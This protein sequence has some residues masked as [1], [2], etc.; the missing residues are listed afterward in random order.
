MYCQTCG[1]EIQPGLNYCNRCGAQVNA[2]PRDLPAPVVV[3]LGSPMRWLA[4]TVCLTLLIGIT[5]LIFTLV[6]LSNMGV[7]GEPLVAITVFAFAAIFLTEFML[8]RLMSR[9]L[10]SAKDEGRLFSAKKKDKKEVAAPAPQQFI[11]PPPPYG[12][13]L[14]SVT[15]HTTRTFGPAYKEPRR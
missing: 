5:M 8:I 14:S 15:D 11:Q 10:M 3:D 1:T 9:L 7:H 13:P 4:A 12:E 2:A 6:A